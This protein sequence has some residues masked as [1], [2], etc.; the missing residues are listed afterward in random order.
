[1]SAYLYSR[2][3]PCLLTCDWAQVNEGEWARRE[4]GRKREGV[5]AWGRGRMNLMRCSR[6]LWQTG[7]L[8]EQR[9]LHSSSSSGGG[10]SSGSAQHRS[11]THCLRHSWR[12]G[13]REKGGGTWEY[14]G[15]T[16]LSNTRNMFCGILCWL[17]QL[18]LATYNFPFPLGTLQTIYYPFLCLDFKGYSCHGEACLEWESVPVST[19]Q[20]LVAAEDSRGILHI[21][22]ISWVL[23]CDLQGL[24]HSS[25]SH[26]LE[27]SLGS[28]WC[29]E[30]QIR[31]SA[32]DRPQLFYSYP[33]SLYGYWVFGQCEEKT[34]TRIKENQSPS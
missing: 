22:Q 9:L 14:A 5:C 24:Y 34:K 30:V 23:L 2:L 4:E 27:R 3:P 29:W 25:A 1:M 15:S 32:P 13:G 10:G 18:C 17:I 11:V 21:M 16:T 26:P 31:S 28:Y 19:G 7:H 12:Q 33:F 20:T 6:E 8:F